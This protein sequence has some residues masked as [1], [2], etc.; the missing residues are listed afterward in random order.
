MYLSPAN[1]SDQE[2]LATMS[3]QFLML[4]ICFYYFCH[5]VCKL[6]RYLGTRLAQEYLLQ[7]IMLP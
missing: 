3:A 6:G 5:T 7:I 4:F 2:S 1:V